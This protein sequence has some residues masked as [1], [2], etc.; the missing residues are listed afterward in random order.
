MDAA[1]IWWGGNASIGCALLVQNFRNGRRDIKRMTVAFVVHHDEAL[2]QCIAN[3]RE[4][5]STTDPIANIQTLS[6]SAIAI[7][8]SEGAMNPFQVA[9]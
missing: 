5:L 9:I 6:L 4:A 8:I 2:N 3:L 7:N 1:N